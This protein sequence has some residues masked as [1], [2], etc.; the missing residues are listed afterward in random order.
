LI[1]HGV[2]SV[3]TRASDEPP[4]TE[5]HLCPTQLGGN[6]MSRISTRSVRVG[7][8]LTVALSFFLQL[9][10]LPGGLDRG[11]VAAAEP[12]T[13]RIGML[14]GVDSLNPYIAY[15]DSSYMVFNLIYDR[16]TTWDEDLVQQPLVATSWE[17]DDWDEVDD[18]ETPAVNEGEDRLWRYH[19]IEGALWHDGE[20][21]DAEDVAYSINVNLNET[22]W[23]FTP[24]ISLKT[25]EYARV[26]DQNTVEVYLKLPSQQAGNLC[27]PIVPEHIWS[28]YTVGEI[29]YSVTNDF[30]V[31]GR[32]CH[33]RA[34]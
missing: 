29:Q 7:V 28:Q 27:I 14:Q 15:E 17:V 22:M 25:A 8:A 11:N 9:A 3:K 6:T 34:E 10:L 24:Y 21:L 1:Y 30:P 32:V 19:I 23:A 2:M 31:E 12:T 18:P 4:L 33:T 20:E 13:V 5:F 16:L 26:I